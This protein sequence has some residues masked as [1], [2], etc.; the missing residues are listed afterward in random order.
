MIT[1]YVPLAIADAAWNAIELANKT[2]NDMKA[3]GEDMSIEEGVLE[4]AMVAYFIC[5]YETALAL[6]NQLVTPP[7]EWPFLVWLVILIPVIAGVYYI[8][9][10][11]MVEEVAKKRPLKVDIEEETF[12]AEEQPEPEPEPEKK[13]PKKKK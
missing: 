1:G 6:A 10:K 8:Q 7:Y 2:I 13:K 9:S 11:K 5:D 4:E 12:E 3:E